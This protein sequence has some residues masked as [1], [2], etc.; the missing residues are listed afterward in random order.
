MSR[1]CQIAPFLN[2]LEAEDIVRPTPLLTEH[3]VSGT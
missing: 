2:G 3:I 1:Y